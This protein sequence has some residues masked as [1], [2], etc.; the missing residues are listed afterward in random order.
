MVPLTPAML[1]AFIICSTIAVLAMMRVLSNI[2]EHETDLH[3]LRNRVKQLQYERELRNAQMSGRI[4]KEAPPP[5]D[6]AEATDRALEA[7]ERVS[8]AIDEAAPL[9]AKAA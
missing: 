4:S 1:A 5:E 8:D 7:A 6:A 3:D 9:P 2:V